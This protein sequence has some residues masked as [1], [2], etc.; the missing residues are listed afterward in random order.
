MCTK[1]MKHNLLNNFD[2]NLRFLE[3]KSNCNSISLIGCSM[4]KSGND[5]A[6][7]A[8]LAVEFL[9]KFFSHL[10]VPLLK[11]IVVT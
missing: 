9:R 1:L 5:L 8:G 2:I 3:S 6:E 11:Q 7:D 10:L 4:Q